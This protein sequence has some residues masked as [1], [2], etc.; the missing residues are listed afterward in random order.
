M[1]SG[2]FVA[3]TPTGSNTNAGTK[4]SPVAS[5][6]TAL[7]KSAGKSFIFVC[8]G[9]YTESVDITQ[10]AAIYGGFKCADW[11]YSGALPTFAAT[12]PDYVIRLDTANDTIIADLE[13]DAMDAPANTGTSS[14]GVF[15]NTSQ[16]VTFERLTVHAGMGAA[17]PSGTLQSLVSMWPAATTLN[18]N[19]STGP[20]GGSQ[21][22]VTCP[23]GSGTTVGGKGGN[24][25]GFSDGVAGTPPLGGGD[26]GTGGTS[27]IA[28]TMESTD[29]KPGASGMNG[30]GAMAL[31]DFVDGGW[32][33]MGGS[34]GGPGGPGQGGGG[35]GGRDNGTSQGGGGGGGA[36]GCGGG[37]GGGGAGGG[38]SI[39]IAAFQSA[40]SVKTST[41]VCVAAGNGGG[42]VSGESGQAVA[43]LRAVTSAASRLHWRWWGGTGG[44]GGGGGGGAGGV[45][46]GVLSKGGTVTVDQTT[47]S[48][49]M[50]PM[51]GGAK[52][53][54]SAGNDG[55]AGVAQP[56]LARRPSVAP[57]GC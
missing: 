48:A 47:Q 42:G 50:L 38:G 23:G 16:N 53:S 39:A 46:V 35:G 4:E 12:K 11:G 20:D 8:E 27:S 21:N 30:N 9:A 32:A 24:A 41:L 37:G 26:G 43:G 7:Q 29:G 10:A 1:L 28:C 17:G 49:V 15:V 40:V 34:G 51:Q 3:P 55:V 33:P 52:G 44:A 57:R 18:G 19:S 5:I 2:I 56:T 54:G 13:L 14:V 22:S 31:G 36:G 25:D 6:T 45:A